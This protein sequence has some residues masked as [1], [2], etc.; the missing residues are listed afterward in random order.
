MGEREEGGVGGGG[1]ELSPSI[2]HTKAY[3]PGHSRQS[4][5]VCDNPAMIP[6]L[7]SQAGMYSRIY[8]SVEHLEGTAVV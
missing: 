2:C 1:V 8:S 3:N 4:S 6:T 5:Q 7:A